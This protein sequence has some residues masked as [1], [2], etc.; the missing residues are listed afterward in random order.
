MSSRKCHR[1]DGHATDVI[2]NKKNNLSEFISIPVSRLFEFKSF[3]MLLVFVM[4]C[5]RRYFWSVFIQFEKAENKEEL[6][7]VLTTFQE[8]LRSK[9]NPHNLNLFVQSFMK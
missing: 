5:K 2:K 4:M 6:N 9:I 3:M 1:Q 8:Q 7:K